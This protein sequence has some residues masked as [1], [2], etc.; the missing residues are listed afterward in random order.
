MFSALS[1]T[2]TEIFKKLKGRG[3]LSEDNIDA[4]MREIRVAL[5]EADVALPVIKEFIANVKRKAI[6]ATVTKSILPGQMVVKIVYDEMVSILGGISENVEELDKKITN[7]MP[8]IWHSD[9]KQAPMELFAEKLN[10]NFACTPPAVVMLIGLQGSGKTTTAAKLALKLKKKH[11]KTVL[12]ISTDVYRPAAQLQLETL[13]KQIEVPTLPIVEDQLPIQI[14][15]RGLEL[16]KAKAYDVVILD[17]AGRL[18]TNDQLIAELQELKKIS[19]PMEI[20]LV[21]DAMIGQESIKVAQEFHNKVGMTGIV[22]TKL[23]GDARG[24]AALSM[25]VITDCPIKFI[26]V[27][28]KLSDL[29]CFYPDRIASRILG[30]GDVVS[31]VEK[32]TANINIEEAHKIAAKVQKGH[33]DMN[34][35]LMQI[36][37]LRKIDNIGS[38]LGLIPGLGKLK[39]KLSQQVDKQMIKRQ[40]A[41]IYSMT[42]K[43]RRAPQIINSSRKKRIVKGAGVT[44]QEVN[45]LLKQYL[46]MQSMVRK[47]GKMDSNSLQKMTK[48]F[49]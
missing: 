17:T 23:D 28:E 35:L 39:G 12:L 19:S 30:M 4:A 43:E 40:E 34:D 44:I 33:F 38:L 41:I 36:K 32:A 1:N 2:L 15:K 22:L 26:G 18:Q 21:S 27:G 6:G 8:E 37:N 49:Q 46:E 25:R 31:L 20:L 42:A 3:T 14:T 5:L 47:I 45:R 9:T 11:K 16:A 48:M 24:G 13:G 10:L 7:E 29:E